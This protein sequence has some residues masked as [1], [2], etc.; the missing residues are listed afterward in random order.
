MNVESILTVRRLCTLYSERRYAEDKAHVTNVPRHVSPV[1]SVYS[2]Y[3]CLAFQN[4]TPLL[5]TEK[6]N[7][8]VLTHQ[9]SGFSAY[10]LR[11]KQ[12]TALK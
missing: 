2:T 12:E 9:A 5:I 3:T 11:L 10:F 8:Y 4:G 6:R 7:V 1:Q